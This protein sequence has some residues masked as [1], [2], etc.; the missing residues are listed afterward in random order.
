LAKFNYGGQAVVEGVMM[1]GR[2]SAAVAIR[3]YSGEI[4]L[5]EEDL[6]PRLYG[7]R[8]FQL[9]FLR[10]I[11]LLWDMLVLGTRMLSFSAAA[12]LPPADAPA[13][14][15]PPGA[16]DGS[17]QD[18]AS[19]TWTASAESTAA[20]ANAR[21][22]AAALAATAA[23]P[24]VVE[25]GPADVPRLGGPALTLMLLVSLGF[26]VAL[27]FLTP[28]AVV[29]AATRW[30]G[31]GWQSLVAEG[32]V[33]LALL[34]AYLWLIGRMKSVQRVFEYH[35]AEHKAINT[36]EAGLPLDVANVRL[37]SRVHTRCGTGFLL[38]VMVVSILV[39]A[40]VGQPVLLL[41]VLSRIVL[42]PVVAAI[43]YELMRLGAANYRYRVVRWLLA[44]GLALQGLTTREPD[45]GQ[46]ECAIAA[47]VR[48]LQRD[49]VT[50]LNR[51]A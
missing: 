17:T 9:P 37:A 45:A 26:A 50:G 30:L 25:A 5:H 43:A 42:I 18:R 1:R 24:R 38:I 48:V 21:P 41:R 36:F 12:S 2:R 14:S 39:F 20:H 29:S 3:R 7:N 10:G 22:A 46:I 31:N 6:S 40:L 8:V 49:G 19:L 4:L 11:L 32:A 35:G 44:P 47:L 27:F 15:V 16:V 34:L 23:G 33:R 28:L 51:V 13:A